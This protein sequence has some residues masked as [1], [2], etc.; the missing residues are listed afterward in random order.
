MSQPTHAPTLLT[1][2]EFLRLP[3]EEAYKVELVR[4][5]VVREPQPGPGPLHGRLQSR[6]AHL[7]ESW[8]DANGDRGAALVDT[9]FVLAEDPGTVRIPDV[10]YVAPARIPPGGYGR[11]LWHLGPDL[12]VEVS[13]PSNTWTEIQER[14][15]DYL[16]AGTR[17]VWV[18]DPPTRTVT[19]YRTGAEAHR[20]DAGAELVDEVLPGFRVRLADLF[21]I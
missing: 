18:V 15:D 16:A 9:A 3:E 11:G 2:E 20:L 10:A 6:I 5:M 7:L 13:S 19:V 14:V 17:S 8:M 21:D 12:A 4:G 1:L